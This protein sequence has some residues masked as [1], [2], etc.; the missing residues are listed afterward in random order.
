MRFTAIICAPSFSLVTCPDSER[1]IRLACSAADADIRTSFSFVWEGWSRTR[2]GRAASSPRGVPRAEGEE[3]KVTRHVTRSV[4]FLILVTIFFCFLYLIWMLPVSWRIR[5]II[6]VAAVILAQVYLSSIRGCC[7][8][9]DERL[10][11]T[12]PV[13]ACSSSCGRPARRLARGRTGRQRQLQPRRR[14]GDRHRRRVDR[15]LDPAPHRRSH[16]QRAIS[17]ILVATFGAVSLLLIASIARRRLP[18]PALR[19]AVTPVFQIQLSNSQLLRSR[20]R[21]SRTAIRLSISLLRER[22]P[23][24]RRK[25]AEPVLSAPSKREQSAVW[26]RESVPLQGARD[27]SCR[28]GLALRRSTAAS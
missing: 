28:T 22:S 10:T 5:Q 17:A 3:E 15:H 26:R 8:S 11:C 24:S 19:A 4:S 23:S 7:R 21:I 12:F 6:Q 18:V 16:R 20:V 1:A 14:H 13:E 9:S 27:R 2:T 25:S